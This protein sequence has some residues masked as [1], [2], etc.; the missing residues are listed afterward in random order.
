MCLVVPMYLLMV[1]FILH[2]SSSMRLMIYLLILIFVNYNYF[3]VIVFS[4]VFKFM[5]QISVFYLEWLIIFFFWFL[6]YMLKRYGLIFSIRWYPIWFEWNQSIDWFNN[7]Y[8]RSFKFNC[9]IKKLKSELNW[10][11]HYAN[12][13]SIRLLWMISYQHFRQALAIW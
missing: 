6:N 10:C 11:M 9:I 1:I 4:I 3:Y 8:T 13:N 12:I 5:L 7:I 2:L